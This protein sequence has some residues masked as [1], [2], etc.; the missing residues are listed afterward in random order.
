[1]FK[2]KDKILHE[3]VK[4]ILRSTGF[5]TLDF[6]D[7]ILVE[8]DFDIIPQID[9]KHQTNFIV[10][11]HGRGNYAGFTLD[12]NGRFLLSSCLVTHNTELIQTF[13][14]ATNQPFAKINMGGKMDSA[15]YLGSSYTYIGSKP[16]ILATTMTNMKTK[17]GEL[18]K[19]GVIFFDEFDK[20]GDAKD[21]SNAFL[22][23]SDPTQQ[24]TFQDT[25]M[26]DINIDLSNITF[27][28]SMNN[29]NMLNAVLRDRLPIIHIKAYTREEKKTIVRKYIIPKLLTNV[30]LLPS[31][32]KINDDAIDYLIS[33]ASE[34][35][36]RT[37]QHRIQQLLNK[38]CV[39]LTTGQT[40][41]KIF[42]YN[43]QL[44]IPCVV[45]KE[46][47]EKLVHIVRNDHNPLI[48]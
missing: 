39:I 7:H 21:V 35:G 11:E 37:I 46:I 24:H 23:I 27:V 8:S 47:A 33:E 10:R 40:Q 26:P 34:P 5:K 36:M 6:A 12:G 45:T 38:I 13:C 25:Y 22:H 19:S 17:S 2:I 31:D 42:S 16:G 1:M 44:S 3:Q 14:E 32:I 15:H 41:L 43:L 20:I 28:Y 29:P 48:V 18:T 30:K 9:T 4:F